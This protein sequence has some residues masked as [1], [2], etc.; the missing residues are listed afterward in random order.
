MIIPLAN[1]LNEEE[2]TNITQLIKDA[3]FEDGKKTAGWHT[4]DLKSNEQIVEGPHH[5]RI[6][7]IIHTALGRNELFQ[8]AAMPRHVRP[9]LVSRTADGGH[10]GTHLDNAIMI[11]QPMSRTDIS[12]T[13]FL[14]EPDS[15]V[16]GELVME[17]SSGERSF[18]MPKGYAIL[19]PSTMLH[20]VNPV[21]SGERLVACTWVQSRIR[22][23]EQREILFDLD[24]VR[25]AIFQKDGKSR[26]FDLL[27][28]S[29]ANLIRQ[30]AD[31]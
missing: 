10:Y 26:D 15:Y 2:L 24:A 31:I 25:R 28:K 3:E 7:Q 4:R 19:Y 17:E 27:S 29:H 16:G 9:F 14:S 13:V 30:W 22:R 8:I 11:G 21:T 18:R 23:A 20:R 12:M 1:L 5:Q 6:N